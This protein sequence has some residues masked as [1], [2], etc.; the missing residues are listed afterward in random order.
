MVLIRAEP[1][2]VAS[3]TTSKLLYSLTLIPLF[4]E[5]CGLQ[6]EVVLPVAGAAS[7]GLYRLHQF[8]KVEMF[9][10]CTPQQSESLLQE[11]CDIERDLFTQ[12]GL[13]FQILVSLAHM[14]NTLCI[15]RERLLTHSWVGQD[16]ADQH[17]Q[18]MTP[19][20]HAGVGH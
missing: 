17:V 19:A 4:R 18:V 7:K 11:L 16:V 5:Q 12:L 2:N 20:H 15:D 8:S 6:H 3:L 13:H 1:E 14:H 9:V 10:L